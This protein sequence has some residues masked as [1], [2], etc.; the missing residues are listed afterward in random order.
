[1][2]LK[3]ILPVTIIALG[4]ILRLQNF[5]LLPIDAHAMRQTDTESVA[6]NFAFR[7]HNFLLPQNSLIRPITNTQSYFFLEVPA[8]QY[9]IG[10]FYML[11]GWHIELAHLI[12]LLLYIIASYCLY[13][14][15]ESYIRETV[16]VWSVFFFSFAPASIF[17]IGH[18]IHPDVFAVATLAASLALYIKWKKSNNVV[19]F[20]L[21]VLSLALST[22]TR[23]FVIIVLPAWLFLAW[24][25]DAFIWEYPAMVIGPFTLYGLWKLWQARFKKAGT[26]WENWVLYGQENLFK[27][28]FLVETLI[29]KNIVGE[30]VG[31]VISVFSALGIVSLL[32]RAN[33]TS[34]FLLL[35]LIGV[36]VFWYF[37]PNGNIYHQYYADVYLIPLILLAACGTVYLLES[38]SKKVRSLSLILVIIIVI[39]TVYNGY[40][41]S[42]YFFT[43]L[44][45]FDQLKIADEIN[46]KIP[47]NARLVY[48]AKLNSIPFSLYHR[49]GWMLSIEPVDASATASSVLRLQKYGADYIVYGKTN[50]D[51]PADQMAIIASAT[52][53]V[54]ESDWVKIY[55]YR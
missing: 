20:I 40:H 16:A 52:N 38:I 1:M 8:Y 4:I 3:R 36:P 12:N 9:I 35:W 5:H 17:F 13:Y 23:P 18:A 39:L 31:K 19:I 45:P 44:T 10:F 14:F 2:T 6:Y 48:L 22:G 51:M 7:E 41:T 55:K 28:E 42:Q 37:A 49:K 29:I 33:R 21:S 50:N 11:F 43:K 26:Y 30:V 34:I 47:F 54:Y 15:V 27:K 24:S 46:K 25:L 32:I 53:L